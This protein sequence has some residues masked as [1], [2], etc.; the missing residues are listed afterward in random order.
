VEFAPLAEEIE[1]K[2]GGMNPPK[3]SLDGAPAD[4][5]VVVTPKLGTPAMWNY[6]PQWIWKR[7]G[8][9]RLQL[10]AKFADKH[11]RFEKTG[12][13]NDYKFTWVTDFPMY[14]WNEETKTWDAAHHPFTS[15]H[16]DDIKAGRLTR[17]G[18]RARAGLRHRAQR[19]RA[20]LR[21]HP[22]PSPGCAGGDLPVAGNDRCRS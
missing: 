13:E 17:Q 16:E 5:I 3:Q 15:P 10:G 7:V 19:H 11:K 2:L 20:R 4:L 12:T 1:A 14:E 8:Q 22:Y 21:L 6:D 9:L 18:R